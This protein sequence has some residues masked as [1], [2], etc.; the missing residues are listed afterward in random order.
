MTHA[1][2]L[3]AVGNLAAGIAH[4]INTP[5]Q[6]V[7]DN[8]HFLRDAFAELLSVVKS[9]K[10]HASD[11]AAAPDEEFDYLAREVPKALEQSMEGTAR[12]SKIVQAMKEFSHPQA[13]E[14]ELV[15]INKA[16]E[17][18][19]IVANNEW[20]YVADIATEFDP[21]LPPLYCLAGELNQVFLNLI[22]NA[23]HAITEKRGLDGVEKGLIRIS[24]RHDG[25]WVEVR[26]SDNGCGIQEK[27]RPRVF[28][29][30][31]T[32][33]P[34]GKGTGQGLAISH[35]IVTKKHG[36]SLTFETKEDEGAT[37]IIR[38]PLA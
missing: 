3:E 36:G 30:F 19:L 11:G 29:Q 7:S 34:V 1:R 2:K 21:S 27:H 6:F 4:E 37:F 8:L 35:G 38:L 24:T 25:D 17:T 10:A 32:T 20:K 14:K 16:I 18:T 26:I 15:D 33:K 5:T 12:I 13:D 9:S 22:V 31:F 23:A 28:E